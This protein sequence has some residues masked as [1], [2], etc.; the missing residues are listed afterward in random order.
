MSCARICIS[1][2]VQGVGFRYFVQDVAADLSL[3]GWVR[4]L[5]NGKVEA[6]L[7]GEK[8]L[9]EDAIKRLRVGP[10]ASRVTAVEV[11]WLPTDPDHQS[12]D[13]QFF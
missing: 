8:G 2:L 12:F 3:R 5:P 4:N 6:E 11:Q 10:R 13:I 9:I 1:G 7:T